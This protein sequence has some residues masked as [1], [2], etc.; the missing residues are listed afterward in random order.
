MG[1]IGNDFLPEDIFAEV[2]SDV[3]NNI[4]RRNDNNVMK[5]IEDDNEANVNQKKG[6]N[7]DKKQ[8][9]KTS[10]KLLLVVLLF[11][12]LLILLFV[13]IDV[14]SKLSI[15]NAKKLQNNTNNIAS[16]DTKTPATSV[17]KDTDN[18]GLM[19]VE[20]LNFGTNVNLF[21]T[22]MD[23]VSDGEEI[24]IHKTNPLNPDTDGDGLSDYDEIYIYKTNPLSSDTDGDGY[25]DTDEI[26]NSYSPVDSSQMTEEYLRDIEIGKKIKEDKLSLI[27]SEKIKN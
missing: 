13:F 5:K 4:V 23:L 14:V 24:K 7:F 8:I 27:E 3:S 19:D 11:V 10:K 18:D 20:E 21:D 2:E 6:K 22:D 1:E 17:L 16:I 25:R 15:K 12:F 26:N 9:S